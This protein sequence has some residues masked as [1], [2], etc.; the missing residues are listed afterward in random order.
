MLKKL[1]YLGLFIL[2]A[3]WLTACSYVEGSG[4]V[5]SQDRPVHGFSRVDLQS[6]G[7]VSLIQADMES[8]TVEAED[9]LIDHIETEVRGDTL[10][11]YWDDPTEWHQTTQ[12][13]RFYVSLK[14]IEGLTLDGSGDIQAGAL[15]VQNLDLALNGSG[16]I[17]VEAVTGDTVTMEING[18]GDIRVDTLTAATVRSDIHGSG[19]GSVAGQAPEQTLAITGSGGYAAA[20]LETETTTVLISGSG[21]ASVWAAEA[22]RVTITGSGQVGYTGAPEVTQHITGSGSVHHHNRSE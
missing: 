14:K 13:M 11:I 1:K 3:L 17:R 6:E 9:N 10:Y 15:T 22:L 18:S 7:T 12:P 19:R 16:D 4:R 21:E 20:D 5:V 8:L 2:P